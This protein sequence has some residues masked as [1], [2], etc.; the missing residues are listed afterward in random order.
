MRANLLSGLGVVLLALTGCGSE[1]P[2]GPPGPSGPS[3]EA[4]VEGPQGPT[5]EAGVQG[6]EGPQGPPGPPGPPGSGADGGGVIVRVPSAGLTFRILAATISPERQVSVRFEIRDARNQGLTPDDLNS[7]GFMAD[8]VIPADTAAAPPVQA[9]YRSFTTCPSPAPHQATLVPCMDNAVSGTTVARDRLTHNADGVWTYRL[10]AALPSTYNPTRTFRIAAQA[11]R[12]GLLA[13]DA[14]AVANTVF[15]TVPGGGTPTALQA[16]S[17]ASCN[18]CHGQL[19]AHGGSRRD[20]RLCISCH[21]ADMVDPDTG[22]NLDFDHLIHRIH[23]GE[24]LP[25]VVGG[26]PYRV[27]GRNG[28]VHDFS[29]VRYPQDLRRCDTC[30]TSEAPGAQLAATVANRT[31]CTGCHD[32]TFIGSGT[33]PM[34]FTAHPLIQVREDSNC[35]Q[36][37]CHAASGSDFSPTAVHALPERRMGAP[38]L[39]LAIES[40][41]G[42]TAG[43]APT[44]TFRMSDRAMN[45][46][47]TTTALTQLRA[48]VAGPTAPDYATFP[49]RSFTLVG[50]GATGMLTTLG[51]GRFSYQFP[52]GAILPSATGSVAVGLE[53]Y[54]TERIT[55]SSGPAFDHRHGAVNPVA[56]AAVG[57]GTAVPRRTVVDNARCNACHGELSFHGG[58]RN[59]NVQYCVTCHNPQGTDVARRPTTAGPPVSIDFPVMIHR[60]HM[61]EH[62]PSVAAGRPYVV[63]GFGNTAHD[64]SDV[65]YPRTPADCASCHASNTEAAPSTRICTSCH[66]S[67]AAIA[68]TQLN[69]T[70][71]G[72]ESCATCHGPGRAYAVSVSHPPVN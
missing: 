27:I 63:Y 72:V 10:A 13:T 3:G 37:A 14:P 44:V 61:G 58:N 41:T 4:G 20:V 23:R 43:G 36:S 6:P 51:A 21:T 19:S 71:M 54:R 9:R 26:T 32:R 34:G 16:V 15:D 66:D 35:S 45:P 5:G 69:T 62:L 12:P 67:P 64:Y 31:L 49:G 65:R 47:A 22:N 24:H 52:A 33:M 25:S 60:I 56:Y 28:S 70:T 39:A 18:S 50:N 59:G 38:T 7:L 48:I 1:G 55:P 40:L 2:A 42:V 11:R 17:Q 53:G 30:H 29:T 46:V 68:H 8:E 57:G